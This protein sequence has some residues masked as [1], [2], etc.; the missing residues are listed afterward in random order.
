MIRSI[1]RVKSRRI[2][3]LIAVM[4][5]GLLVLL[6]L[7]L[8]G[9]WPAYTSYYEANRPWTKGG[10]NGAVSDCPPMYDSVRVN[11]T[12]IM[13]TPNYNEGKVQIEVEAWIS[14]GHQAT[15]ESWNVHVTSSADAKIQVS[16]PLAFSLDCS[17]NFHSKLC[18]IPSE[19]RILAGP[20]S[21][22]RQTVSH[23]RARI[24][25]PQEFV[26][27]FLL[28][29]PEVSDGGSTLEP[30]PLKFDLRTHVLVRGTFGC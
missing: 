27:G 12:G 6:L 2:C 4:P 25:L 14:R 18:P 3:R 5:R 8:A 30:K 11:G 26:A 17:D 23:F 22:S 21:D 20:E 7:A 29:L 28:E 16:M 15:F 1:G 19:Q 9:C 13:V 10:K 24:D